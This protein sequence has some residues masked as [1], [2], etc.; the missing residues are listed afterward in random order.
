MTSIQ[1]M[2]EDVDGVCFHSYTLDIS[3]WLSRDDFHVSAP[4]RKI[5]LEFLS[6]LP[7]SVKNNYSLFSDEEGDLRI[8]FL[9]DYT[10]TVVVIDKDLEFALY[11]YDNRN[12]TTFAEEDNKDYKKVLELLTSY[13]K[14]GE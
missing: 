9:T 12:S 5:V 11:H 8:E 3:D 13:I 1:T 10:H 14:Q 4:Q 7:S 6:K 2:P